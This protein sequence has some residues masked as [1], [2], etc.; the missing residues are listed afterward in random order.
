MRTRATK[1]KGDENG[2]EDE[3]G[4]GED[5]PDIVFIE[6]GPDRHLDAEDQGVD[7]TTHNRGNPQRQF[8]QAD[9]V[10]STGEGETGDRPGG[11]DTKDGIQRH[12]EGRNLQSHAN[13]MLRGGITKGFQ[14]DN[15]PLGE[16]LGKHRN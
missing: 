10:P 16:G 4:V 11:G 14:I 15:W 6:P 1:G 9:E 5:H 7:K 3:A 13:G 8:N 2:G 12:S